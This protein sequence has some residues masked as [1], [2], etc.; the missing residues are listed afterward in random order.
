MAVFVYNDRE[1]SVESRRIEEGKIKATVNGKET[2]LEFV[3]DKENL[4][5]KTEDSALIPVIYARDGNNFY[6]SLNGKTYTLHLK[7]IE[8]QADISSEKSD[9]GSIEPPMPG[10]ILELKVSEGDSVEENQVLLV[11]ESMKLQVEIKAP[12]T[13]KVEKVN[14]KEGQT[15]N[16]GE[17]LLKLEKSV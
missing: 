2:E 7:T 11:M 4:F 1:Y 5:I 13:G 16:A 14:V 6:I 10:K 17:C 8:E 9:N 3:K 15:V 12:F